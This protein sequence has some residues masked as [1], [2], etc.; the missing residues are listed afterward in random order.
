[1]ELSARWP[2]QR[3]CGAMSV[4]RSG[5]YKWKRRLD[6]PCGRTKKRME[7]IAA[8]ERYHEMYP[9]H[10]YRWLNAKIKLDTGEVMSDQYAHR[11]CKWAGIRSESKHSA[12]RKP[13]EKGKVYPNMVMASIKDDGPLQVVV[14]D[15]TAFWAKRTYWEL[16]LYM[17]LWDLEIVGYG[18]SSRRGDPGGYYAG[19]EMVAERKAEG[20]EGLKTVLH[21][22][23]GSVYASKSFND[24]LPQYGM[25]HSMSRAG[26]PTDNGAM[27]AINGWVKEEMFADF[28]IGECEDV[29]EFVNKYVRF[30]NEERPSYALGYLTPK[31]F[32]ELYSK[33]P[34][35][36]PKKPS[37]VAYEKKQAKIEESKAK[38]GK[39]VSTK[40]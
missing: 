26:T 8:F 25:V 27:E 4:N 31:A 2:V 35:K 37:K 7:D 9:S 33:D 10:G 16:T 30:F 20:M 36:A 28:R 21:T 38:K 18:L 24:L 1:M 22:D 17:D 15:M 13:G 14:S 23:Q 34:S 6:C 29:P 39:D 5:F 19:L 12:Y 40:R 32:K 11:C 3:L